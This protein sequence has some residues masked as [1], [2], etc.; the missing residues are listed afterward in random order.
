MLLALAGGPT[1][2]W[3]AFEVGTGAEAARGHGTAALAA[4]VG[5]REGEQPRWVWDDTSRW[6]PALLGAG[7]GVARCHDLRLARAILRRSVGASRSPLA[8]M[9]LDAWDGAAAA[10]AAL[11]TL[12]GFEEAD[13]D[14]EELDPLLEF[15]RQEE[16]LAGAEDPGRLRLLLAAESVGALIAREIASAGLPWR[17]DVH[18]RVLTELLGPRPLFGGRPARL[19]ALAERLRA[20]LEAPE[21][22]PDSPVELLRALRRAGLAVESTRSWELSAID[23]PAI[24]PLLEYKKLSRLLT[25][26]GWAWLDAWVHEGRFR[27]EYVVGGVV[28]GRWATSGGGALQLPRQIRAAVTADPGWRLVVAD[29]AQLEPRILAAVAGDSAMAAAGRGR[30][31]YQGIVDEGVVPDRPRAKVA[32]LGAM[33]GA[34]SGEAGRLVPRLARA[35]P[36]SVAHVEAAARAGERGEP[37][38][39]WL[40]RSSPPGVEGLEPGSPRAREWG[41]FTRNFVVQGT[42]A[43]WALCWMG[44]LRARLRSAGGA[45]GRAHLVYFLHDEVIV[46]APE[47]AADEAAAIVREAAAR[48]GRALFGRGEVD[49]P[50]TVAVVRAY[51]EA[52]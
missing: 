17:A 11:D 33:Y 51:E 26:N 37:V 49:F 21:L 8:R 52:K 48:A 32:M 19:E 45:L 3:Q 27:P 40:G 10:P 36:L 41:R 4:W 30:D 12:V 39:T 46:H 14:A 9:P 5:S 15:A 13:G 38:S 23:H 1:G 47:E 7:V 28:T 16:A 2:R 25:A 6:Y 35:Y 22:T 44:E 50:V 29:A 43:E 24:P 20:E 34:T 18:D 31:L 42:A